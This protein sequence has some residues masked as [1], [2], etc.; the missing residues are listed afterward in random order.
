MAGR[1]ELG[2][3]AG[4]ALG[5]GVVDLGG[6]P[7][8][9][10]QHAGLPCLRQQLGVE[11]GVLGERL[12]QARDRLS[13]R[14][15]LLGDALA[16]VRA[17]AEDRRLD[18]DDHHPERPGARGL[19]QPGEERVHEHGRHGDGRDGDRERA[20]DRGVEEAGD[21]EDEEQRLARHQDRREDHDP[22]PED[23]EPGLVVPARLRQPRVPEVDPR[24]RHARD[25]ERR[26][27]PRRVRIA[28][29]EAEERPGGQEDVPAD[30]EHAVGQPVPRS[31]REGSHRRTLLQADR[32]AH[33]PAHS[34]RNARAASTPPTTVTTAITTSG[35]SCGPLPTHASCS[36]WTPGGVNSPMRTSTSGSAARGT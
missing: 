5:D 32:S 8:A 16:E 25:G 7:L 22:D 6:H 10:L 3:D 18:D 24:C 33:Q 29:Q 31:I 23:E 17:G 27:P 19:R 30:G 21:H 11:A 34:H 35:A 28:Q 36:P 20:E 9:F 26:Q 13:T 4:Q 14:L 15:V 1:L 2:D 12:L